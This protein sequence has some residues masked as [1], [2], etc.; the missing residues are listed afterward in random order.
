MP[1]FSA[2]ISHSLDFDHPYLMP[3]LD[4]NCPEVCGLYSAG[5]KV[6]PTESRT[7]ISFYTQLTQIGPA[8]HLG[9]KA[10]S[11]DS[12]CS[13]NIT[14]SKSQKK[15][16]KKGTRVVGGAPATDPMPWMV[17]CL[18]ILLGLLALK[19]LSVK[20][21]MVLRGS[22]CGASLVNSRFVLTAAHCPCK[23]GLCTRGMT[24]LGDE[25]LRIKV[26]REE[27]KYWEP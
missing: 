4:F 21:I 22:M 18:V 27:K 19:T 16:R 14:N 12:G 11:D 8:L 25:P 7:Q 13:A 17:S 5:D 3:G 23:E 1:L 6:L 20:V 24:E 10:F 26:G 9:C 15:Q 2:C